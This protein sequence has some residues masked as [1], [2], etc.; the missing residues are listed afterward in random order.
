MFSLHDTFIPE[1]DSETPSIKG[2]LFFRDTG[3]PHPRD[4]NMKVMLVMGLV[5]VPNDFSIKGEQMCK[6]MGET[7]KNMQRQ[8]TV[9]LLVDG[10]GQHIGKEYFGWDMKDIF[11][12][13]VWRI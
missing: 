1:S 11:T 7:G 6:I 5:A 4:P 3:Q 2:Q 10:K 13:P 12:A 9:S 8:P